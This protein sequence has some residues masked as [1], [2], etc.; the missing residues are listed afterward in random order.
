M[1][2]IELLVY[3]MLMLVVLGVVGGF[4]V[5]LLN[6]QR[7]VVNTSSAAASSQLVANTVETGIRN[8]TAF[9]L[10]TQNTSDQM[11]VARS[12]DSGET[13]RW[14]CVAWYYSTAGTGSV[15]YLRSTGPIGVPNAGELSSWTLLGD[16][17]SPTLGAGIFSVTGTR[18]SLNFSEHV[19]GDPPVTISTMVSPRGGSWK[20]EPCF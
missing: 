9:N 1:G 10:T 4:L 7:E 2:L 3:S 14:V 6:V 8:A 16:G 5:V 17:I 12:A 20:G 18:L 11:L 19:A 15:R 13:I